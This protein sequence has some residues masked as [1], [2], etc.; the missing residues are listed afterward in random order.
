MLGLCATQLLTRLGSM[1]GDRG[2]AGC[3][4][5]HGSLPAGLQQRYDDGSLDVEWDGSGLTDP[6]VVT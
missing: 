5:L 1:R 6:Q 3:P 4:L 2:V